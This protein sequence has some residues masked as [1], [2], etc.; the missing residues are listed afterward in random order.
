MIAEIHTWT[1]VS[2]RKSASTAVARC[3]VMK[4]D[5]FVTGKLH[6]LRQVDKAAIPLHALPG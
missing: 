3:S 1:P 4:V 5:V 6:R 2:A